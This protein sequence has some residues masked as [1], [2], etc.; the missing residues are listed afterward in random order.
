MVGP[1]APRHVATL[2]VPGKRGPDGGERGGPARRLA[3]LR[4]YVYHRRKLPRADVIVAISKSVRRD[5]IAMLGAP[6]VVTIPLAVDTQPVS[7]RPRPQD[8]SATPPHTSASSG[9]PSPTTTWHASCRPSRPSSPS[10]RR[11]GS[12]SPAPGRPRWLYPGRRLAAAQVR[13]AGAGLRGGGG[14]R[15]PLWLG[16]GLLVPVVLSSALAAPGGGSGCD[17]VVMPSARG[18]WWL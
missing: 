7:M 5:A 15:R 2:A 17:T 14:P 8:L 18:S 4:W 1:S 3:N 16:L 10:T 13:G 11:P 6:P 12:M 9:A